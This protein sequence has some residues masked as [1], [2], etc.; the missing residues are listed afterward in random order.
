MET[1]V[2]VG[3]NRGRSIGGEKREGIFERLKCFKSE[4]YP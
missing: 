3:Y 2:S 1:V 4:K